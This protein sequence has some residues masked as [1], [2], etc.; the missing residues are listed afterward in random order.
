VPQRSEKRA[1]TLIELLVSVTVLG[2]LVS[3]LLPGLNRARRSAK[4]TVC[5]TRLHTLGQGLT[6]Y[7]NDFDD[8]LVPGRMPGVDDER[9]RVG[10]EGG[11]KYRPTFLAMMGS[12]VGVAPFD[13]PQPT[14]NDVDRFGQV[15]DRQ[16]YSNDTYLCPSVDDWVDERNGAYGYNYQFLG[17]SRLRVEEDPNSFKNWPTRL[18]QAKSPSACVAVADSMGTAAAFSKFQRGAYEDDD[19]GVEDSG[20]TPSALGNE[21]FNLDP[22]LIDPVDGE[23]AEQKARKRSAPHER[24]AGKT[25]VLWLDGH[26]SSETLKSLGYQIDPNLDIVRLDG[27]NRLFHI[28]SR[29]EP[30]TR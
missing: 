21:G 20:I 3:I 10:I 16:N 4:A 23:I 18:S 7:A 5:S 9:W 13:D 24:H 29:D 28:Y 14:R 25:N 30:W 1:F 12:Q 8:M 19:P 27:N 6:L 15:G 22:P 2:L 11:V 26:A 17:N